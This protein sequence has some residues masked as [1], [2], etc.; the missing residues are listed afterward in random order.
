MANVKKQAA[1]GELLFQLVEKLPKDVEEIPPEKNQHIV[2][3]SETGHNHFVKAAEAKFYADPS[4]AFTC[5]LVL[6]GDQAVV[7]HNKSTDKHESLVLKG[8][9]GGGTVFK[10]TLQ[11]EYTPQGYRAV[12]D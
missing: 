1:Q 6:E 5:Y 8:K 9:V 12:R 11:R 3:H 4:D 7:Q 2:G 10:R